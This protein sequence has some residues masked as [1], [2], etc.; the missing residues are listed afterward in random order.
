MDGVPSTDKRTDEQIFTAR[1][2]F[3]RVTQHP[4]RGSYPFAA[5]L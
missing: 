2:P 4:L 3:I 1:H 5:M